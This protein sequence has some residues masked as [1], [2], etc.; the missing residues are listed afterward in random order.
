MCYGIQGAGRGAPELVKEAH[1]VKMSAR[2]LFVPAV[3]TTLR[4]IDPGEIRAV[5]LVLPDEYEMAGTRYPIRDEMRPGNAFLA[6][7]VG[8]RTGKF[9]RRM[10]TRSNS[11]VTS[12][13]IL[14]T[15]I[16]HTHEERAD[17]SIWWQTEEVEAL[18]R[19]GGTIEVRVGLSQDGTQLI[20]YENSAR[21]EDTNLR[22][23]PDGE[24]QRMRFLGIAFSTGITPFLA[25]LRYMKALEFGRTREHPGSYYTLVVSVRKPRHLMEH[26]ELLELE[27]K[28]PENFRYYPVLTREWPA[29][30]PYGKGRIIRSR[31][32]TN[33]EEGVD[34]GPLLGVAPDLQNYHVRMCGNK[35]ARNQLQRGLQQGGYR[36]LSFRSEIW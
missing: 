36:P 34:L 6:R 25:H 27:R 24:W 30:W 17:S 4:T 8:A 20:L 15:I 21:C 7:P 2:E 29:D 26:D 23:E 14:E 13:R 16:N 28:F 12:E 22:L 32:T 5:A 35:T 1:S 31:G 18:Q 19:K 3:V 10:Y 9:R 33:G 11:A